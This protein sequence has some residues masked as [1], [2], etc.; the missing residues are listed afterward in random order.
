MGAFLR[1][2]RL[3]QRIRLA[4][5]RFS[6]QETKLRY[7]GWAQPWLLEGLPTG[8]RAAHDRRHRWLMCLDRGNLLQY[9]THFAK[10]SLQRTLPS[11]LEHARTA[12]AQRAAVASDDSR[13][14]RCLVVY[15]CAGGTDV[16]P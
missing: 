11:H 14:A 12:A 15:L 3:L 10:P 7:F 16:L 13:P 2:G 5:G 4:V 6:R 9:L 8:G 1:L